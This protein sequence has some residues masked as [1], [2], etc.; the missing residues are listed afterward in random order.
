MNNMK[1]E[2]S[3]ELIEEMAECIHSCSWVSDEEIASYMKSCIT[4]G[5]YNP[6]DWSVE[7]KGQTP[8]NRDLVTP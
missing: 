7:G 5:S 1:F 8:V 2:V 3:L 4:D 6:D